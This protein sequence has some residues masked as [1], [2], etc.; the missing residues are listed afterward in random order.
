MQLNF[1]HD[2][3]LFGLRSQSGFL[4][5]FDGHDLG[6]TLIFFGR[7]SIDLLLFYLELVTFGEAALPEQVGPAVETNIL[8]LAFIDVIFLDLDGEFG[9]IDNGFLIHAKILFFRIEGNQ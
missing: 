7:S 6:I 3:R 2:S 8:L 4:D 5:A 1:S 9:V